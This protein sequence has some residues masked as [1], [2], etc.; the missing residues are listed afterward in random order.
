MTLKLGEKVGTRPFPITK[1]F[2]GF[3]FLCIWKCTSLH[4]S[5]LQQ[6]KDS[7]HVKTFGHLYKKPFVLYN[8]GR[9]WC[10]GHHLILGLYPWA[11]ALKAMTLK[12]GEA[13]RTRLFPIHTY[14][15][16]L[17]VGST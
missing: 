13:L 1:A 8:I 14:N 10:Q 4:T 6:L 5:F 16:L 11:S 15:F 2:Q 3:F 12:L 9:A 17:E 7:D